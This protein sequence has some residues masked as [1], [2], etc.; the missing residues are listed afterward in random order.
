VVA[1][2]ALLNSNCENEL[3]PFYDEIDRLGSSSEELQ[4]LK[5]PGNI[6][7]RPPANS[8]ELVVRVAYSPLADESIGV[9]LPTLL[10][11]LCY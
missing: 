4:V 2:I 10:L 8:Y 9:C 11:A 7:L 5:E 6:L 1:S 3:E